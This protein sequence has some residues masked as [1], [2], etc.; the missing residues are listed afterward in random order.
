MSEKALKDFLNKLKEKDAKIHSM[1]QELDS[2]QQRLRESK[3]E[4][5]EREG[6][7]KV[8]QM[9]L[10]SCEKQ[11]VHLADEIQKYEDAIGQF[12]S[13]VEKAQQ[14]Y[15]DCHNEYVL[16]QQQIND[17]KLMMATSEVNHR[18]TLTVVSEKSKENALLKNELNNMR[19]TN[20]SVLDQVNTKLLIL[21]N[22]VVNLKN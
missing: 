17:L 21:S 7:L 22:F 1:Q 3:E 9:N 4:M 5:A 11:R 10:S 18:E 15:R 2:T 16:G 13:A 8:M 14:Q 20:E 12:K 6:Q 19:Q